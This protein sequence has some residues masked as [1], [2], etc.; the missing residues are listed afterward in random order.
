MALNETPNLLF[1]EEQ[2][3]N[4]T[5]MVQK[6]INVVKEELPLDIIKYRTALKRK[7]YIASAEF[8]HKFKHKISLFSLTE[9]LKITD[10]HE[11]NLYLNNVSLQSDF[12]GILNTI[13]HYLKTLKYPKN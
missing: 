4:N 6:I 5:E 2:S 3:L 7:D 10:Q 12:D 1:L 13:T 9:S 11:R 8:V